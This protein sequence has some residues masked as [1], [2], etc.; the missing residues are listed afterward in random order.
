M[1]QYQVSASY[2]RAIDLSLRT[3]QELWTVLLFQ[4]PGFCCCFACGRCCLRLSAV[5]DTYL[6]FPP[7]TDY[8]SF[9]FSSNLRPSLLSL[10]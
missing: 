6:R 9:S 3:L 2:T 10:Y 8:V 5:F 4:Q 1:Q 7:Q